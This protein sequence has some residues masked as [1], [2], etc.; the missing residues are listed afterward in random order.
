[1]EHYWITWS[2]HSKH[3]SNNYEVSIQYMEVMFMPCVY[4]IYVRICL[5]VLYIVHSE[6]Q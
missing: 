4:T 6:R 3:L 1:M 5:K 2:L